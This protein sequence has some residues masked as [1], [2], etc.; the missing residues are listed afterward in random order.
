MRPATRSASPVFLSDPAVPLEAQCPG[1]CLIGVLINRRWMKRQPAQC[2]QRLLVMPAIRKGAICSPSSSALPA[3]PGSILAGG[4]IS[5]RISAC[6]GVFQRSLERIGIDLLHAA[7]YKILNA[8]G[9]ISRFILLSHFFAS[10]A[11]SSNAF[12]HSRG[13]TASCRAFFAA[14]SN[15]V[16]SQSV[17]L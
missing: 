15:I 16:H 1:S 3:L 9:L 8:K 6:F 5:H 14:G 4:G 13:N 11:P 10:A 2:R 7:G 12:L 17:L